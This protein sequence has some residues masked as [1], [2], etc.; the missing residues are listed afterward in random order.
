MRVLLKPIKKPKELIY[1][2]IESQPNYG[3]F[4]AQPF[5]KGFATTIGNALRRTLLSSIEGSA[6]TAI[7]IEGV[8]HEFTSIPLY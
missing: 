1:E 6:I 7:K 5:E 3:K 8:E 2:T 4:I